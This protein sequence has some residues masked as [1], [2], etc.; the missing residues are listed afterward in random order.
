MTSDLVTCAPLNCRCQH[1]SG[2][3]WPVS[4]LLFISAYL[5][6]MVALCNRADHYIFTLFLSF[7]F[8][9]SFFSSPNL[10]G[11]RL[12]V[13]HSSAHGVALVQISNA[14]LKCTARG[15]LQIQDAKNRHL[16]TI[17]QLC[18]AISLQLRHVST[19]DGDFWRLFLRPAFPE[20]RVHQV[21]DLHLKFAL[22][23]HHVWKYGRHPVYGC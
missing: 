17:A 10:S 1:L 19:I 3:H 7:F 11:R 15:S 6:I 20:S 13:Y 2:G 21:S 5:L 18:F 8:L 22:R 9:S 16:G 23:P 4:Y 12:D 14:G